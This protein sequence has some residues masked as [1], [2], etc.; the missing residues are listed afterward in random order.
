MS[1][2]ISKEERATLTQKRAKDW[3]SLVNGST[4]TL[5][6]GNVFTGGSAEAVVAPA[7]P[8]LSACSQR[9]LLWIAESVRLDEPVQGVQIAGTFSPIGV[10]EDFLPTAL[11][12]QYL[13]RVY[14]AAG[15]EAG[16]YAPYVIYSGA[17]GDITSR[18]RPPPV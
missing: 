8:R 1:A 16:V 17:S 7:L 10:A 2:K 4:A 9:Q 13:A 11:Q 3:L 18:R 6:A 5:A 12:V 15:S 14:L